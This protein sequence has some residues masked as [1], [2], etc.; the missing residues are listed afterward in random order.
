MEKFPFL[1]P[2]D[3]SFFFIPLCML[4]M[5]DRQLLEQVSEGNTKAFDNLFNKYYPLLCVYG[6]RFVSREDANEIAE[7]TLLWV[8]NHKEVLEIQASLCAYLLKGVYR[9]ALNRL[10]QDTV[11]ATAEA[12][13]YQETVSLF[14]DDNLF[15]FRELSERVDEAVRALPPSYREAFVLHRFHDLSYKEIAVRLDVSPKTVEYRISQA[16]KILRTELRDYLPLL[17]F[18]L[19]HKS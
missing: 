16:L 2:P 3:E 8:W 18:L 14:S 9:R 5:E 11:Q 12:L 7:D 1:K 10:Q 17:L 4:M 15:H 6:R 13:F 19:S